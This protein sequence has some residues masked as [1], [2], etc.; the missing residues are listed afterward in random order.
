MDEIARLPAHDRADLL[1]ATAIARGDMT[2]SLVEKDFWVCWTLRR[3]FTLPDPPAD[4]VFKGGTSLSKVFQA[5][6]RFSEDVDLSF[7]RKNL[8]FGGD[9]DPGLGS[10]KTQT[11]KRLDK[12]S[13]ACRQ[14]LQQQFEP[15]LEAA[16][17]SA[18]E[19]SSSEKKWRIEPDADDPDGLT[20]VFHYPIGTVG[21]NASG[22]RYLR[23]SIRM[24][25]GARG[26]QW[27]STWAEVTPYASQSFPTAFKQSSCQVKALAAERTFW[28][29]ATIL[30]MIHYFPLEKHLPERLS[31]HY[32]D[33]AKL[34]STEAG[35]RAV[36]DVELLKSVVHHKSIFFASAAARYDL[37]VPGTLRLVPPN[38]RKKM[39]EDDYAKMREMIF[40]ISPS[41]SEVLG[42]IEQI[43]RRV[44]E[45]GPKRLPRL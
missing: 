9:K 28:E 37:A 29:K 24:E 6:D 4:L 35:K 2:P 5:I 43:E 38:D 21:P 40:G 13:A 34:Y 12:L 1:R 15:R 18:L 42:V 22:P 33:L 14:M 31:R 39:L 45:K 44:N 30:H 36:N 20:L 25:F 32:Y 41:F 3:I 19:T 17:C 7:N 16:F 26:E 10:S 27:P 11:T 23:P 8:G